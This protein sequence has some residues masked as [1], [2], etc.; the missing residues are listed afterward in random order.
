MN[1]LEK[2]VQDAVQSEPV[3]GRDFPATGPLAGNF[4]Q[5]L[6]I[7]AH[8]AC[9]KWRISAVLA[10]EFPARA[11]REFSSLRREVTNPAASRKRP[12]KGCRQQPPD[13]LMNSHLEQIVTR[14]PG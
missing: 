7:T 4:V 2:M 12:R 13:L 1:A 3:S 9:Y 14:P 11:G 6:G 8:C 10:R 5:S